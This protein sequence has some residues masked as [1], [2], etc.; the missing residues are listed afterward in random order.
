[1]PQPTLNQVHVDAILTQISVAYMQKDEAFI[2]TKVFPLIPVDKKSDKYYV[3]TKN[4]WFR[5]EAERR[6]PATESAGSGYN[7]GTDNYTCDVWAIHKDVD[8]QVLANT[9]APLN[10]FR[11][12]TKFVTQKMLLRQEI[13]WTADYFVS[14]VWD[15][16][17]TLTETWDDYAS[18]DPIDDVEE[19]KEQILSTT[20]HKANT[21]ILGYQS[22]RKLKNHP[23]IIDRIKYTQFRIVTEDLLATLFG[24]ER[25]MVA[26]AI[27]ATNAEG[28]TAAYSFIQGKEALLLYVAKSPGLYE[29]SAGYTFAWKGVSQG[30]GE[31]IGVTRIPMRL[32]KAERV[33]AEKAWDN[34]LV[35]TDMGYFWTNAVA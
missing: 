24:V 25:V 18:S 2:S 34:K 9:D 20:G 31:T 4:D 17:K 8:N 29:P 5:D 3:Y 10:P 7:V 13:Q 6:A 22:F 26:R 28:A 1:M 14:G 15:T 11:D 21:L 23:D 33:E 19:A 30:I 32:K 35:A 12:A 16:D 27:K